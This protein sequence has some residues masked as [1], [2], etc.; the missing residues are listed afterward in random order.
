M[1]HTGTNTIETERLILR[2]FTIDDAGDMFANWANDSEVTKY[3]TWLPHGCV[4]N[5]E[6]ILTTWISEYS[7][8]STYKW[9]I[10]CKDNGEPVIGCIDAVHV[11]EK[12]PS[13][14]IGY[15][16]SKTY[17]GKGIMTE[18]LKEVMNYLFDAGFIRISARH[19]TSNPASGRVMQKAGMTYEGTF[20]KSEINNKGDII[21]IAYY[22]KTN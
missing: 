17:W 15:C 3:L 13:C 10:I 6:E 19:D 4:E 16:L 8:P 5:T 11:N 20:S 18:A 22:A 14:E 2:R 7:S 12:I 9:A 1:I 21:D